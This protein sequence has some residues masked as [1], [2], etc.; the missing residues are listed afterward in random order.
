[1]WSPNSV[2]TPCLATS[3]LSLLPRGVTLDDRFGKPLFVLC[4]MGAITLMPML[5]GTVVAGT[6][7]RPV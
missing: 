7:R 2:Q 5:V 1:M 6:V 4:E 3:Y